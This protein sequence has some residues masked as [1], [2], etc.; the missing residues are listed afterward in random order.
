MIIDNQTPLYTL[1]EQDLIKS[2]WNDETSEK[3]IFKDRSYEFSVLHQLPQEYT[4]RFLDWIEDTI[5]KKLLNREYHLILHKF[6]EGDY[7]DLHEDNAYMERG[8]REY[9]VGFHLNNDYKGGEFVV[10]EDEKE[11]IIG[12]VPG[13][14]YLFTSDVTHKINR[15]K[16]KIR[17]SIILFIYDTSF[18]SKSLI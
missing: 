18:K 15:V 13:A 10:I 2:N 9:A 7:F 3:R 11:R 17:W 1:E 16:S 14:P 8:K 12:K 6:K 4:N 5:G